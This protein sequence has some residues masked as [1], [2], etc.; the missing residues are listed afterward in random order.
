M[1]TKMLL[2]LFIVAMIVGSCTTPSYLP[3]YDRIET[4]QFGSY[5]EVYLHSGGFVYGELIAVDS[6]NIFIL[7]ESNT[8]GTKKIATVQ[9]NNIQHF[10]LRYARP[11][12]YAW[13][14][15]VFSLASISHGAFAL[16]TFPLNLI[17]TISVTVGGENAY[18]YTQRKI[19]Y[20]NMRM[21]ARFPQGIP[22]DIDIA[23]IR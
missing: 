23:G 11:K 8:A 6:N 18:K 1:K 13:S 21:F 12:H 16:L 9:I 4:N 22:P 15:P 5:V 14:I 2:L 19:T 10:I 7:P 3:Q 17:T 20:E